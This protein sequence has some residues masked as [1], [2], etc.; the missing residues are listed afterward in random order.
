M[1]GAGSVEKVQTKADKMN[2]AIKEVSRIWEQI[3]RLHRE[4][5]GEPSE[6]AERGE[7]EISTSLAQLLEEGPGRIIEIC[8][9]MDVS[10]AEIKKL[11][12]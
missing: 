5:S 2:S 7:I 4:I 10:L 9:Q 8:S 3:R 12:F 6:N 1:N 11:L